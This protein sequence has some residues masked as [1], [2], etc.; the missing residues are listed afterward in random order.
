MSKRGRL[1]AVVA[2]V[3]VSTLFGGGVAQAVPTVDFA[4][5][6]E[7]LAA[8]LNNPDYVRDGWVDAPVASAD[9]IHLGCG[10]EYSGVV[11]IGSRQSHGTTH[12]IYQSTQGAFV[13]CFYKLARDGAISP[14]PTAP[15]T[16]DQYVITFLE[17]GE[18]R[19]IRATMVVDR[20]RKFVWAMF[21]N[22]TQRTPR[23]NNWAG[24]SGQA[25]VA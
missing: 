22:T 8:K 11:H 14:D 15:E 21:T 17:P 5:P 1:L 10:D 13:Q 24:C 16:R 6:L 4:T 20:E 9:G 25:A 23:G 7:C 12:P 2:A 3:I 19:E 18:F